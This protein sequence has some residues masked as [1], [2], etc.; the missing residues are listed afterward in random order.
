VKPT[1]RKTNKAHRF[2]PHSYL[3][4]QAARTGDALSL[5]PIKYIPLNQTGDW[6]LSIGGE[7]REQYEFYNNPDFGLSPEDEDGYL[8][9][10][11]MVHGDLHLGP[12]FRLFGQ[13]KSA[14][15]SFQDGPPG[16]TDEDRL[17]V[18]QAFFDIRCSLSYDKASSLTLRAGRQEMLYGS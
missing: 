7:V 3:R 14:F 12:S 1:G 13:L 5:E 10:R 2:Y 17:D 18:H 15:A 11:Y 16:P 8:L 6:Y 9:Q 4:D